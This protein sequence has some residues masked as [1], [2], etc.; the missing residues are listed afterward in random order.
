MFEINHIYT[1]G[2][3]DLI[4]EVIDAIHK[5]NDDVFVKLCRET[6]DDNGMT[7]WNLHIECP[8]RRVMDVRN[9]LANALKAY[10][11]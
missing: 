1:P 5:G 11:F 8:E 7:C 2:E 4:L 9:C 10:N 3:R 6:K